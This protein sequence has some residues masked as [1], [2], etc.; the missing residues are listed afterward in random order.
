[1]K[2]LSA[3]KRRQKKEKERIV[4]TSLSFTIW[5]DPTKKLLMQ[6]QMSKLSQLKKKKLKTSSALKPTLTVAHDRR[7]KLPFYCARE[8]RKTDHSKSLAMGCVQTFPFFETKECKMV[9]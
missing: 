9:L 1:M 4:N 3:I 2:R 5:L 7:H 8:Q 6:T